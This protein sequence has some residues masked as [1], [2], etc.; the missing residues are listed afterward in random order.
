MLTKTNIIILLICL[1]LFLYICYRFLVLPQHKVQE[2]FEGPA[3]AKDE[4][5]YI[6]TRNRP[7][8]KELSIRNMSSK[9]TKYPIK[10][11]CIKSSLN[12]ALSGDY[13]STNMVK[14]VL[15][16]G[17]RFLDFEVFY[18]KENEVFSP[19]VSYSTDYKFVSIDATNSVPLV[20][21]LSSIS[22]NAFSQ[23]APNNRDPLFVHLR[24]KSND[25]NVYEAVAKN[26]KD[27]LG[28]RKHEGKIT[29]MT[30]LESIMGK[31]IVV[32]DKNIRRDY[33]DY[34]KSLHEQIN[35]ESGSEALNTLSLS[36][37]IEQPGRVIQTDDNNYSTDL[38]RLQMVTPNLE[39]YN[40]NMV[41]VIDNFGIQIFPAKFYSQD[42]ELDNYEDIFNQ[43]S[44]GIV[45]M[46]SMLYYLQKR[47]TEV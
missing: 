33:K 24:I 42:D 46:G 23:V 21:I 7:S 13:I 1:F 38:D 30:S 47:K 3:G 37:V 34:S 10:D 19:R 27:G 43:N 5:D 8:N 11:Y 14:E 16:R 32:M 35:L 17:C 15:S 40:V 22:S 41:D 26:I 44:H 12:S 45:P 18:I 39:K 31:I 28:S 6:K 2:S 25:T 36:R 9:M 29:E 20:E 4:V